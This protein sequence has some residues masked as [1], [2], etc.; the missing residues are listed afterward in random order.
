MPK[1][2]I[3]EELVSLIHAVSEDK[4]LCEALLSF[5][6]LP[7]AVR[8]ALLQSIAAR[9]RAAGEETAVADAVSALA[10]PRLYAA[11]CDTLRELC[12]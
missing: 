9:M 7:P 12:S 10:E 4:A 6:Q 1:S 11:A 8:Q 5:K 3:P 2:P